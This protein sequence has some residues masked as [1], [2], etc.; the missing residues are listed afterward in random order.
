MYYKSSGKDK[1][2]SS[3][4]IDFSIGDKLSGVL[5][6]CR[7]P[8]TPMKNY[9]SK[10]QYLFQKGVHKFQNDFNIFKI[11]ATIQK[12]K[13]AMSFVMDNGDFNINKIRD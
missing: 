9:M 6:L 10:S 2:D 11:Y 8:K 13:V 3:N 12:L 1:I 4:I 7:R 5:K